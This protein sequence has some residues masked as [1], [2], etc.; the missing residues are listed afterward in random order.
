[1]RNTLLSLRNI[2]A[3]QDNMQLILSTGKKV[4]SAIDN[5]SSYYQATSLT[6]RAADLLNLL[7]SM[8]QGIQ[9]IQAANTGVDTALN[10][11]EQMEAIANQGESI[12]KV[13]SKEYFE[14]LVGANGAVVTTAEELRN[15][16][17]ANKET[18][19]VYGTI[20]LGDISTSGGLEL[21]ANQ[22]L[23]G[24]GYFGDFDSDVDKFSSITAVNSGKQGNLISI[25]QNNSLL[26]GVSL[27]Y[28]S[29]IENGGGYAVYVRGSGI[30][31]TL[32]NLDIKCDYVL[33]NTSN[34]NFRCSIYVDKEATLNI[35]GSLNIQNSGDF[36]KGIEAEQDSIINI[37][38]DAQV[39]IDTRGYYGG[40]SIST[41]SAIINI[42]G[43]VQFYTEGISGFGVVAAPS[44]A[45]AKISISS[46]AKLY[47]NTS[48]NAFV[49]N[50]T[51]GGKKDLEIS[52]GA[53]VAFEKKGKTFYYEV[54]S[55][56]KDENT[57]SST[58]I[59]SD[60]ITSVLNVKTTS[61]WQLPCINMDVLYKKQIMQY[62]QQFNDALNQYDQLIKDS[63]YKGINLLKGDNLKINFNETGEHNILVQGKDITSSNIGLSEVLWQ[64]LSDVSASMDSL[65][66][67]VGKL[68]S[69]SEDL[70]SQFN[71]IQ[72]RIDFTSALTNVLEEGADKLTLAD[73]N[74]ASAQYLTLQTRQSLA[75]NSLS[76]AAQSSRGVLQ[77]FY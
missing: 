74:E 34:S 72:T 28:E 10:L 42:A 46:T 2:S 45:T 68:R 26:D 37:T 24:I 54:Q 52:Q 64:S 14:N 41:G 9:T 23:V 32:Q 15:A 49:S 6:N 4:N 61:E 27:H 71:I 60:N 18:I 55:D 12:I 53:K 30:S 20:D 16:I 58:T 22:K 65:K 21:K 48:S 25:S 47:F 5:P 75:I 33:N 56:Y 43:N 62:N 51:S 57:S 50:H 40:Y 29:I 35:K 19:C 73:M 44:G 17:A 3:Q 63:Y 77:L 11:L 38:E 70:G 31:S 76:L 7:N 66:S 69:L 67:A 8:E 36:A 13:P 1:M 39:K 59:S